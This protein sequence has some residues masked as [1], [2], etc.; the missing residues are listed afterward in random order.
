MTD[1]KYI[2]LLLFSIILCISCSNQE[3]KTL[4]K[5]LIGEWDLDSISAPNGRYYNFKDSKT[6]IFKN[7]TD[8]SYEWWNGDV[9]N[10]SNGKYFILY[11]PKRGLKTIS[12]IP[13]IQI[14]G[15]DTFRMQYMN[16]DIMSISEERLKMVQETQWI[17]RDSLPSLQFEIKY[18]YKKIK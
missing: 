15:A 8:Y 1:Q 11:N 6:L 3:S 16:F 2:P 5:I 4:S 10:K 17:S 13:D 18:I 7:S 12:F 14:S 9:G